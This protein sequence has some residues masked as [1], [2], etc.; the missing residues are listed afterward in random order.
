MKLF[1]SMAG[2]ASLLATAPA[3]ANPVVNGNTI[4]W[5]DNGWYQVQ[6]ASDYSTVC[7]GGTQ[8]QVEVGTYIVINHSTGERFDGIRVDAAGGSNPS[9]TVSD[10]TVTGNTIQWPDN[11]WYQVQ[12]A[13][14]YTTSCEGGTECTVSDGTYNVINLT[15]GERY[16]NVVVPQGTDN[17][18]NGGG[19]NNGNNNSGGGVQ[20]NGDTISWPDDGWY[21]VQSATDY[22]TACEGGT[23]CSVADGLYIVINHSTGERFYDVMVATGGNPP[24]NNNGNGGNNNNGNNP[25][26]TGTGTLFPSRADLY[27]GDSS[28]ESVPLY[29][30]AGQTLADGRLADMDGDGITELQF[31]GTQ[32]SNS[33]CDALTI[34]PSTQTVDTNLSSAD[35][36]NSL[37]VIN[38]FQGCPGQF[39]DYA[40]AIGDVNGDGI[41]D[42]SVRFNTAEQTLGP[43]AIIFGTRQAGII[44]ITTLDGN[45]GFMLTAGVASEGPTP[46]GDVNG[47]GFDD[48][49]FLGY[50]IA[51]ASG[52]VQVVLAGASSFPPGIDQQ[53]LN[54]S[55]TLLVLQ[56]D[57]ADRLRD[58]GDINRDGFS[59]LITASRSSSQPGIIYGSANFS[60]NAS[61]QA[62]LPMARFIDYCSGGFCNWRPVGDF[63]ADGFDD[64][65]VSRF[66]CGYGYHV[67]VLY[68]STSGITA[69]A[70]ILDYPVNERTRIVEESGSECHSSGAM[71][72]SYRDMNGDGANDLV[73]NT[74]TSSSAVVLGTPGVR[75]DAISTD[76]MDGT[77]G[78]QFTVGPRRAL[79]RDINR[80]GIDDL[81][82]NSSDFYVAGRT[83]NLDPAG[84]GSIVVQQREDVLAVYW[85]SPTDSNPS[86]Y[87]VSINDSFITDTLAGTRTATFADP[88]N[89][90][91]ALMTVEA[92]SSSGVVLGSNQ[93]VIP[94]RVQVE[95]LVATVHAP[96][97]VSIE[98]NSETLVARYSQYLVWRNGELHARVQNGARSYWD[99]TV[100]PGQTYTYHITPDYLLGE[101]LNAQSLQRWPLR[102]RQSN[103]VEVTTPQ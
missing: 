33:G 31:I 91:E 6:S 61:S 59:D 79:V 65:V 53:S 28:T 60:V 102:Q 5:P 35:I 99:S 36:T 88:T 52:T 80:D 83:R 89:G 37:Q 71:G 85:Q 3:F 25:G 26:S 10:V 20:V 8:C 63:D 43:V 1:L 47:D 72:F 55:Q 29:S 16:T 18:N 46:A 44:D 67:H 38:S 13:V 96:R 62:A 66:S 70:N 4:S 30:L 49:I 93:R 94:A 19:N 92:L 42:F 12:S 90:A 22:T 87:R 11:G 68:G 95:N 101:S 14:D 75:H 9:P 54:T 103:T 21:Q 24:G 76:D 41:N 82:T 27:N 74:R 51:G 7:E 34:V 97:L 77:N 17:G 15:N 64:I 57:G 86:S 48:L 81:F 45:N 78:F 84:P 50:D 32:A 40:R 98:F 39:P 69:R 100:E 23:S 2:I 73:M 58:A 56:A